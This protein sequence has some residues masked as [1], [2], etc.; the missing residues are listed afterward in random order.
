MVVSAT[1]TRSFIDFVRARDDRD[2]LQASLEELPGLD[3]RSR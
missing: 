2:E 1:Q 3:I